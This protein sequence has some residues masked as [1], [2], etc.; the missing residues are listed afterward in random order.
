MHEWI[1]RKNKAV[2][3]KAIHEEDSWVPLCF[4]LL[5]LVNGFVIFIM[6]NE[7]WNCTVY[8]EYEILYIVNFEKHP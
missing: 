6:E 4:L 3:N 1:E 2:K 8:Y 7:K 5:L